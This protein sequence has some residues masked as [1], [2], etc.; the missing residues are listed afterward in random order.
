LPRSDLSRKSGI[1]SIR[2][3]LDTGTLRLLSPTDCVK[4]RLAAYY[5]WNDRQCLQQAIWVAQE[6]D[7]DWNEV[8][9]WSRQ[10]REMGKFE[11]FRKMFGEEGKS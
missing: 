8:E 11:E 5:H 7:V 2:I 3:C 10:E 9:R 1:S 4:D 6:R